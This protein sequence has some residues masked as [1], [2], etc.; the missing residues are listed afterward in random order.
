MIF[1]NKSHF[2]KTPAIIFKKDH[3]DSMKISLSHL[4]QIRLESQHNM[5]RDKLTCDRSKAILLS[6]EKQVKRN[7]FSVAKEIQKQYSSTSS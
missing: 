4:Q 7:D 3:Y 2:E 6:A 1:D 5:Y